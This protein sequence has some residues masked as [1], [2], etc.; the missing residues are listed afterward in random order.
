MFG[1]CAE[2]AL[3]ESAVSVKKGATV[4]VA[5][6]PGDSRLEIVER[7]LPTPA[8]G[9]V[10]IGMRAAG[11]CGSDLHMQYLPAPEHRRDVYYGLRTSP[12][13][14][15]GHEAAGVVEA[16]G[17][18]VERLHT[19]DRV[20]VHHMAGCGRCRECRAGWDI[21]CPNKWGI[22]GLDHDGG[23][24][25]AMIARE[26]DCVIVPD[27][28]S[29]AEAC[30]YSCGAGTGYL[31]LKRA[32]FSLGDVVAIVGLGPV[33]VAA[34]FFA[35]RAGAQ[36]F[37][38]DTRESRRQYGAGLGLSA[39]IN[40]RTEDGRARLLKETGGH[41][42][43]IVIEATG[44]SAARELAFSVVA[45][46]GR[47]VCVGFTDDVTPLHL[48]RDVIQK[49]ADV[50]GAWMFPIHALDDMLQACGR[51]AVSIEHL[52][53]ERYPLDSADEAWRSF[54]AGALGKTVIAWS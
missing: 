5:L 17:P 13:V 3:A 51:A 24:Q 1:S 40:P 43:D 11:L 10:L 23:M 7:E 34:A 52:I 14:V 12:D 45:S 33:G 37:G 2:T 50:L 30:Y 18:G 28:I 31:A 44:I 9:E 26:R 32:R 4:R 48:Q 29:F 39:S 16:V 54:A 41:G 21:N 19:G 25:D 46:H 42:A 6:M 22:Y 15:P 38:F 35:H 53:T 49:Q 27:Q 8:H 20:T 36:V 47:I